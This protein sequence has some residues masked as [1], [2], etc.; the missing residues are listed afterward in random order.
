MQTA[1][2]SAV[3][4]EA[5][6]TYGNALNN[7]QLSPTEVISIAAM[8]DTM[9]TDSSLSQSDK[10]EVRRK[11][12]L[13]NKIA[14]RQIDITC[15]ILEIVDEQDIPTLEQTI[16]LPSIEVSNKEGEAKIIEM[17]PSNK[18]KDKVNPDN[19]TVIKIKSAKAPIDSKDLTFERKTIIG[20]ELQPSFLAAESISMIRSINELESLFIKEVV[21]STIEIDSNLLLNAF[22]DLIIANKYSD[23]SATLLNDLNIL[24]NRF[25]GR[26]IKNAAK[27]KKANA[28][29]IVK[30]EADIAARM[31]ESQL[32]D[33]VIEL[34]KADKIT[35]AS[36]LATKELNNTRII[37]DKN[38]I[39]Q[40]WSKD[41]VIIWLKNI[42][43]VIAN[44]T[45]TET[46][47]STGILPDHDKDAE[48]DSKK[49]WK[50]Y[51]EFLSYLGKLISEKKQYHASKL[52]TLVLCNK[53]KVAKMKTVAGKTVT[54]STPAQAESVVNGI[55]HSA[56]PNT[57]YPS[58]ALSPE[59][60]TLDEAKISELTE[61]G[62]V[63][64][65]HPELSKTETRL[66]LFKKFLA[67]KGISLNAGMS[68]FK[69]IQAKLMTK[70][71]VPEVKEEPSA[72][73]FERYSIKEKNV[74]L[75]TA[76]EE[77]K[78]L[79][80]LLKICKDVLEEKLV[81]SWPDSLN[82]AYDFILV[83]K[84]IEEAKNW[85]ED[86]VTDWYNKFVFDSNVVVP[87]E[88]INTPEATF[89]AEKELVSPI[90][91]YKEA[92][93]A[94]LSKYGDKPIKDTTTLKD[95]IVNLMPLATDT[96]LLPVVMLVKNFKKQRN[97]K[98]ATNWLVDY[99]K[100][101]TKVNDK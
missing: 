49:E 65:Q 24:A 77:C 81:T 100:N 101:L 80:Q 96:E 14:L 51:E 32:R 73:I 84:K 41:A 55:M 98:Q 66:G 43:D 91:D 16:I 52:A 4:D 3:R 58:K 63:Y 22:I 6:K 26:V 40:A 74:E 72:I 57:A 7:I 50:L 47:D 17:K 38:E 42:T 44:Q 19:Q 31:T 68:I 21:A 25:N 8:L 5:I 53:K 89:V 92:I 88:E 30:Q 29:K 86:Q 56:S 60:I 76:A 82:L 94:I 46:T 62:I 35:K 9:L 78:T 15:Q 18:K 11:R 67:E 70:E 75:Y 99:R 48:I 1:I 20:T 27:I 23:T 54:L 39:L 71:I 13:L 61:E 59:V 90:V 37:N 69:N 85:T 45:V 79:T 83:D 97:T 36:E 10:A 28:D 12:H 33:K 64:L 95:E 87:V 34:L 93:N 2:V